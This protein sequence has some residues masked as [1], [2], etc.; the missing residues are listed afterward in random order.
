[1]STI[2]ITGAAG[3]IGSNLTERLLERGDRVIGFDN[4]DPFY[5]RSI[6]QRN[7]R[8]ASANLNFQLVEAD[9]RD[10]AA[11][12]QVYDRYRPDAVVHLAARAGVRPS[13]LDPVGY[14]ETNIT[15]TLNLLSACVDF[16]IRNFIFASSS[17]VYGDSAHA[18]FVEEDITDRPESPYAA[19]KKAGEEL[20]YT[21]HRLLGMPLTCLR[22]FTVY[23]PRQRPD[24]AISKFVRLIDA[25]ESIPFFG[26]GS[27]SRDYTYVTDT[28]DGIVAV[29]D[30][31][32][33]F[34][35]YNLGNS[36][37]ISLCAMVQTL[38]QALNRRARLER[39]PR[40][41]G[42][43]RTTCADL[44]NA[45]AGLGYLPAVSFEEGIQRYVAWWKTA[46]HIEK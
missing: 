18:P 45:T 27:T 43:V 24:L 29:L 46:G 13:F 36:R 20:C 9:V 2:L 8:R 28:I 37:P 21:Y 17:S 14:V 38:E 16:P 34:C 30:R 6:K 7:L 44:R 35:V 42:D 4:F 3:F 22:F 39:L 12:R 31:P 5:A 11:V 19:T 10:G 25:G 1:M 40:Q 26:D 33:G 15:G 23:G 41:P 32:E